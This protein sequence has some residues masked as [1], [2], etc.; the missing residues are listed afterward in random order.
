MDLWCWVQKIQTC[1]SSW[2]Q[3]KKSTDS[4][5]EEDDS[6]S[7]RW[8]IAYPSRVDGYLV[9]LSRISSRISHTL[10]FLRNSNIGLTISSL[11]NRQK[12][13]GIPITIKALVDLIWLNSEEIHWCICTEI[14]T[15]CLFC[16]VIYI[17][18]C[19]DCFRVKNHKIRDYL[20]SDVLGCHNQDPLKCVSFAW[21]VVSLEKWEYSIYKSSSSEEYNH[22]E[23]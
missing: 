6:Q 9:I 16:V 11:N 13:R 10:Y 23:E 1:S 5:E 2:T 21:E 19:W 18:K 4:S 20:K 8:A 12:R 7:S 3:T 14:D 15:F 22:I 17:C